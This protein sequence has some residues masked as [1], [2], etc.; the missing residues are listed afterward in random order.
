M[1]LLY[2]LSTLLLCFALQSFSYGQ[3][4]PVKDNKVKT[5]KVRTK[6]LK[7]ANPGKLKSDEQIPHFRLLKS[8][9]VKPLNNLLDQKGKKAPSMIDREPLIFR[10]G[11]VN[12]TLSARKLYISDNAY[13]E[14]YNGMTDPKEDI[15]TLGC[16]SDWDELVL[17]KLNVEANKRYMVTSI[18]S[19][20]DDDYAVLYVAADDFVSTYEVYEPNQ[21]VSL[22]ISSQE[23]GEIQLM[24]ICHWTSAWSWDLNSMT[25]A[26]IE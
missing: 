12:G 24:Y 9:K 22:V 3:I 6:E 20:T 15:I 23:S 17:L 16:D 21:N 26:E 4:E 11:P 13:L 5:D 25:I 10:S 7:P 19:P 18:V 1:K 14:V 8:N 2:F